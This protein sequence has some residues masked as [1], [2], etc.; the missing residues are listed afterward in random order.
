MQIHAA[1]ML[2]RT[3]SISILCWKQ[4]FKIIELDLPLHIA[5]WYAL[6]IMKFYPKRKSFSSLP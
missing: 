5:Y 3:F 6:L 4:K 1:K 2:S